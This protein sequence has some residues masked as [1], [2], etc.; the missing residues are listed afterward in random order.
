MIKIDVEGAEV[1]I[2]QD[3]F[4]ANNPNIPIHLSVHPPLFNQ[5]S[6]TTSINAIYDFCRQYK[7]YISEHNMKITDI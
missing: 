6:Y 1:E 7:H 4:F 5:E 3:P 2:I